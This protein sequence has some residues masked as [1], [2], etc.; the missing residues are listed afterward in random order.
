M[1]VNCLYINSNDD[2]NEDDSL[3]SSDAIIYIIIYRIPW[4]LRR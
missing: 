1:V 3:W 4:W 2:K